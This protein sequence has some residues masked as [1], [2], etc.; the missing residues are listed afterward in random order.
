LE[1]AR[2]GHQGHLHHHRQNLGQY[3]Y[4]EWRYSRSA[5][6]QALFAITGL[7]TIF[8]GL[9]FLILNS[10]TP[11]ERKARVESDEALFVRTACR[12]GDRVCAFAKENSGRVLCKLYPEDCSSAK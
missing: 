3:H 11:A 2:A 9:S 7:I 5:R 8:I 4:L 10:E 6:I 1:P 12:F